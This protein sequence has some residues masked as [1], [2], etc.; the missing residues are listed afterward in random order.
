MSS[1]GGILGSTSVV[2]V[3][4]GSSCSDVVIPLGVSAS[5]VFSALVCFLPGL[6]SHPVIFVKNFF[7]LTWKRS[8]ISV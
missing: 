5:L 8:A 4:W 7:L 1:K 2:A 3:C 6:Y